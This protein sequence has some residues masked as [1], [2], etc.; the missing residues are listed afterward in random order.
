MM[1]IGVDYHPS[2]QQIAFLIEETIEQE[3]GR[4]KADQ[5]A[6]CSWLQ[7]AGESYPK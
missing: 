5:Q 2:F 6:G 3:I 1:I 4:R 7:L